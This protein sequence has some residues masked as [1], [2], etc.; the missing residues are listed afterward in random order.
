[1]QN[2]TFLTPCKIGSLTVPNRI[3]MAPMGT[4][5]DPDG[6]FSVRDMHYYE[7]R[8]RGG[9][10]MII[11]GRVHTTEEY[12]QRTHHLLDQYHHIGRLSILAERVHRYGSK[13]CVQIGPG[14]GRVQHID[15]FTPPR[16]ASAVPSYYYPELIC[17]PYTVDE[18]LYLAWS[19]GHTASLARRAGADAVELH[20]YGGYLLDQVHTP[21]WNTRTDEYGGSLENRLRFTLQCLQQI[22]EQAGSDFP[23]IVKFTACHH[24]EGGRELPEG[25]EMARRFEEA[26]ADA[27]HVDGGCID[28][29]HKQ[30][31][32]VYGEEMLLAK[33]AAAVKAAVSI[34]VIS[35]GKIHSPAAVESVLQ[36]GCADFVAMGHQMMA[37]PHWVNK[38]A[39]GDHR[40]ILPCIGCNECLV[41]SHMGREHSCA[42]N[43]LCLREADYPIT[44]AKEKKSVLVVGGGPGGMEA[45]IVAAERGHRV[46]LWE[47]SSCL[48]G[49]LNQAG[50]PSFKQDVRRYCD[51]M[52][53]KLYR[54][55]VSV[56]LRQKATLESILSTGFD[57]IIL[58]HGAAPIKPPIPG[59]DGE[60][61]A[62]ATEVFDGAVQ[63]GHRTA[64][65]GGGLVGCELALELQSRGCEVTILEMQPRIVYKP[66]TKG[67]TTKNPHDDELREMV[68]E[69]NIEVITQATVTEIGAD[70][71]TYKQ[72]G[73]EYTIPCDTFVV[74]AGY[75]A[76]H[77]LYTALKQAGAHVC[78]IGNANTPGLI[79]EAV[80]EGF[81]AALNL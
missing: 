12:E 18:I 4:K 2:R 24:M 34:P 32:S 62:E 14:V 15:P 56:H 21:L 69:A 30:I 39:S 48:G 47:Q 20:A 50:A 80:H 16:A 6:G 57:E 63:P 68:A 76:D 25:V 13:L 44:E 3:L 40:D 73:V 11:T 66:A 71:V 5:A 35:H 33:D 55:G 10:G 38:A 64:I 60:N 31:P 61:V 28:R 42:V 46:E 45:A 81:F 7:E 67:Y 77:T 19:V 9:C 43:P 59:I 75:R 79:Y 54:S 41:R 58:A 17:R 49:M 52:I 8:A 22:K 1:M 53:G 36:N 29:W 74:A 23:V 72:N 26:G 37:D 65:L 27:L 51:Y 78:Q 70:S